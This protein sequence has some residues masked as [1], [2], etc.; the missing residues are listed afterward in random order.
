MGPG[1]VQPRI[2]SKPC[3]VLYARAG[4][5]AYLSNGYREVH[6]T[7]RINAFDG[8]VDYL[9][10]KSGS[11]RRIPPVVARASGT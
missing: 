7:G 4:M 6:A 5:E 2:R 11:L 9:M 3:V 8:F 10:N 1:R